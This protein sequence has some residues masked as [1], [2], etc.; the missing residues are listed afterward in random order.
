VRRVGGNSYRRQ[1]VAWPEN[2]NSFDFLGGPKTM[3]PVTPVAGGE[4]AVT[5]GTHLDAALDRIDREVGRSLPSGA[6]DGDT[7]RP[8]LCRVPAYGVRSPR[9]PGPSSGG[10]EGFCP[11]QP[12]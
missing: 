2:R 3:R 12:Q 6:L 7:P 9:W 11:V 1:Y 5:V 8:A 10:A 4:A